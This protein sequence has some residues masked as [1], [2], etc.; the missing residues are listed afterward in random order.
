YTFNTPV[1]AAPSAQ[2]G[3]VLYD[4]FHVYDTENPPTSGATVFPSECPATGTP[5][6]PQEK[7]LEFMIF[8]LASSVCTPPPCG[9]KTCAQ[10]NIT[11]G[12]AND[13]CGN[14]IQC[15]SCPMGQTCGGGGVPSVCG[16]PMCTPKTCAQLG[17]QC[18]PA[19]D[20][21]GGL[22]QCGTCAMNMT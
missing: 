10:Q 4:D 22:L 5:L 17:I 13:G 11:C 14:I 8:D 15:G 16:M 3:R 19:G 2:C 20:G 1:G 21:C 18:G 12:P 7:L 6:T 9:A